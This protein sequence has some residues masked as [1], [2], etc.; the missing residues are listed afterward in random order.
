MRRVLCIL[1]PLAVAACAAP[2]RGAAPAVPAGPVAAAPAPVAEA[3]EVT[4]SRLEVRVYRDGPMQAL[5][6]DHL[7]TSQAITGQVA[8]REP[9]TDSRFDL[10]LPLVSLVV[11]DPAERG[12]A[13]GPFAAPVPD[14]DR[15]ATRRN[16]L[17]ERVL[18]AARQAE[19]LLTAVSVTGGPRD[20]E[21]RVRV[22]LAGQE[23]VL[24][25]PFTVTVSGGRLVAHADLRLTHADLGLEPFAVALGALRVREDFDVDLTVEARPRT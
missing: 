23:H 7:I 25:V 15:E 21:A 8:L 19:V 13:G 18:D 22:S 12:R 6:H 2:P 16:M 3:W 14:K 5:G 4:G 9:L 1:L 10:R 20:Y 24:A 17:G 11:D